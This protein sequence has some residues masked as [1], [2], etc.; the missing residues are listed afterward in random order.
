[1]STEHSFGYPHPIAMVLWGSRPHINASSRPLTITSIPDCSLPFLIPFFYSNVLSHFYLSSM[2]TCAGNQGKH[3][4]VAVMTPTQL[5]AAGIP[6]PLPKKKKL[7]KDQR[8]AAL[9]ED[10]RVTRELL[11]MVRTFSSSPLATQSI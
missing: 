10:L 6:A 2:K 8:I 5:A 7:S 1:M 4:A 3:P 9:E 11:Q